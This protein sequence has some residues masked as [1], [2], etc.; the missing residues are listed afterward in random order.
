MFEENELLSDIIF[1][2]NCF[3]AWYQFCD[4]C[5]IAFLLSH[6]RYVRFHLCCSSR[7][8]PLSNCFDHLALLYCGLSS[9]VPS[10]R[11]YV[12]ARYVQHS[13]RVR[14][15]ARVFSILS[16]EWYSQSRYRNQIE[17]T[18][19]SHFERLLRDPQVALLTCELDC[20]VSCSGQIPP[21]FSSWGRQAH[22]RPIR[23]GGQSLKWSLRI[24]WLSHA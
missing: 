7:E 1:S 13:S 22:W 5:F 16:P 15:L 17:E 8:S 23:P 20:L 2:R 18:I 12:R 3:D 21:S 10:C 14:L 24:G 11:C 4:T 9:C 19:V 6:P